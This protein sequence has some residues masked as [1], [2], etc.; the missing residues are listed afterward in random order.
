MGLNDFLS[1]EP[2]ELLLGK[3]F[4][5][6]IWETL[7]KTMRVAEVASFLCHPKH[8]ANYPMVAKSLRDIQKKK[9]R[10]SQS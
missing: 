1:K 2:F 10:Y 9:H 8:V 4:K 5:L 6:E 7:I 3:K